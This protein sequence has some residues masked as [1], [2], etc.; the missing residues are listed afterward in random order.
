MFFC[1][2]RKRT[3]ERFVLLQK[4]AEHSILF[5][6][7]KYIYT[8]IYIYRFLYKYILKKERNILF[9]LFNLIKVLGFIFPWILSR[10]LAFVLGYLRSPCII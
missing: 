10:P 5:S 4:N 2:E 8:G 1:K 6:I 3:R 9:L 7:D